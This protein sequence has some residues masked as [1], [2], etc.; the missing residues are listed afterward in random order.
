M[1]KK[2]FSLSTYAYTRMLTR[3]R[4]AWEFLR[5]NETFL[6]DARHHHSFGL[7]RKNAHNGIQLIRAFEPQRLAQSWGLAF[8]PDPNKNGIEADVFWSGDLY[9]RAINM[10]VS[11][12]HPAEADDIFDRCLDLC[13][14]THFTDT[15]GREHLL[16]R[17]NECA[18]QIR[19]SGLSLLSLEPVRMR[20]V[21]DG[22]DN[23][24]ERLKVFEKAKRLFDQGGDG[25]APRWSRTSKAL[26]NALVALDADMAGLSHFETATLLYGREFAAKSWSSESDALRQEIYRARKRGRHLRDGGYVSLLS[27]TASLARVNE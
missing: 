20:I 12:R 21:I 9:P 14:I 27:K 19:C 25:R 8:F 23:L 2:K 13:Q 6:A 10:H 22:I 4:W 26:R 1:S 18:I 11:P 3:S 24:S 17:T 7:N 16:L 5:R 15:E